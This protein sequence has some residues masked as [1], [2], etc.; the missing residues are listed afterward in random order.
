MIKKSSNTA[1]SIVELSIV[2]LITSILIGGIVATN[3]LTDSARLSAAR[4]MTKF[5][6]VN[7]IEG[8]S[9]WLETTMPKS[10]SKVEA[11]NGATVSTWFD[12]SVNK[13]DMS[14]GVNYESNSIG[15]LPGLSFNGSQSLTRE[16]VGINQLVQ[17]NQGTVFLVQRY[18]SSSGSSLFW[19]DNI[20]KYRLAAHA[21]TNG[22]LYFNF[23]LCCVLDSDKTVTTPANFSDKNLIITLSKSPSTAK[24]LIDGETMVTNNSANGILSDKSLSTF[25][26]GKVFISGYISSSFVGFIGEVII[27]DRVLSDNE[28]WDIEQY[29]SKK[30][31]I[32]ITQ[33]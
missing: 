3:N 22:V 6:P 11:Q 17:E 24:I 21:Y 23:G 30:W 18:L 16:N 25:Y 28:R 14:G 4:S 26:I 32:E 33:S 31:D 1:F 27:F 15:G 10:I 19:T 5:S 2:I 12:L 9:L 20:K 29:L 7:D 8:L 13:F